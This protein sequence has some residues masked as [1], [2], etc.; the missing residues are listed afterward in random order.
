[1]DKGQQR[2]YREIV[3]R[4]HKDVLC[5][6]DVTVVCMAACLSNEFEETQGTMNIA[7]VRTLSSLMDK[8]GMSPSARS[9]VQAVNRMKKEKSPL[10]EFNS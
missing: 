2:Y 10:D 5:V 7:R 3:A 6:A 8:L 4:C 9:K 1:M